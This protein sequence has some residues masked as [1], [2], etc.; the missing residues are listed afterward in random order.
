M[1]RLQMKIFKGNMDD[2]NNEKGICKKCNLQSGINTFFKTI[3]ID[4]IRQ[5]LSNPGTS[6]DY[7]NILVFHEVEIFLCEKCGNESE[8]Q[9][10]CKECEDKQNICEGC[11]LKKKDT[12]FCPNCGIAWR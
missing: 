7:C 1:K 3:P 4:S 9:G 11:G 10:L 5:I 12:K 2:C 6:G 8:T